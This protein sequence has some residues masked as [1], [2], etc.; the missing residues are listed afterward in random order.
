MTCTATPPALF[1]MGDIN[2]T[3]GAIEA[4]EATGQQPEEFLTRHARLDQGALS[5]DDHRENLFSL[6][7]PLRIFS[8]FMTSSGV[9]LWIITEADRSRTTILLPDEY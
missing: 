1:E 8:A 9:K 5:D 6:D 2:L 7:K 4:L 3:P